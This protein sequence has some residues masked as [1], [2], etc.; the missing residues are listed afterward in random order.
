MSVTARKPKE[1][2]DQAKRRKTAGTGLAIRVKGRVEIFA[3]T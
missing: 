1:G 2:H 3:W